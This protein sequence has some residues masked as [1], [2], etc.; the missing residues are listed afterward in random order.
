MAF[1]RCEAKNLMAY[2]KTVKNHFRIISGSG[3]ASAC[4]PAALSGI[5][6]KG[7]L[8]ESLCKAASGL[9]R[10]FGLYRISC[11]DSNI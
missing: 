6:I 7:D 9:Q 1:C 10:C 3:T 11:Y 5:L 2:R 4:P 8:F